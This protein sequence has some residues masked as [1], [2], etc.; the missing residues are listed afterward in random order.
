MNQKPTPKCDDAARGR[1]DQQKT[2]NAITRRRR[3]KVARLPDKLRQVVNVMLRDGV[4][5]SQIIEKLSKRGH[6]L[7]YHNLS[8]WFTG[9]YQEWLQGQAGL[10][11]IRLKLDFASNLLRLDDTDVF[12]E[13]TLRVA[14]ARLYNLVLDFDPTVLKQ[15]LPNAPGAYSRILNSLCKLTEGALKLERHRDE[16]LLNDRIGS[17][18]SD[19]VNDSL[20][21]ILG[22]ALST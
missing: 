22:K 4:P 17:R 10:D 9:G 8:R 6:R 12:N 21:S 5:Y 18:K 15:A 20:A 19:N 2:P 16:K 3:G 7:Q 1:V 11:E 14:V 13:A